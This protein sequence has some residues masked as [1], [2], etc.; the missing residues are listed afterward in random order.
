MRKSICK[1]Q[2]K[3]R[4]KQGK[5]TPSKSGVGGG[6]MIEYSNEA[7]FCLAFMVTSGEMTSPQ[8][9]QY[10]CSYHHIS[11]MLEKAQVHHGMMRVLGWY[12][13]GRVR[14]QG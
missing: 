14:E 3:A 7:E 10:T 13:K 8:G 2:A 12:A 1:E 4:T 11:F 5:K 9:V 6:V